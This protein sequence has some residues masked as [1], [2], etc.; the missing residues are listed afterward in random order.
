M[1]ADVYNNRGAAYRAQGA[2][3]LSIADH[4]KA[5]QINP[6]FANAYSNRALSYFRV[7]KPVQGLPD[8]QKSLEL[9]PGHVATLVIRGTIFE[10]LGRR[11]DAVT[12]FRQAL[13]LYPEG[14]KAKEA[15]KRL[16]AL[17]EAEGT[18]LGD[19]ARL[20]NIDPW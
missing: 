4:S 1:D 6:N 14:Q 19:G 13:S 5:I 10:A 17:P 7:G 11:E 16:G 3:D 18:I 8:A 20:T 15:L 12:D 9:R 2:D